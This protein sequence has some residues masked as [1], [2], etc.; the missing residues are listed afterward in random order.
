[1]TPRQM[2]VDPS[3]YALKS[4]YA[5]TAK[6]ITVHNTANDASA[7]NEIS[8]MRNNDTS[9]SFHYAIDDVEVVQGLP[10]NRNGYH[11]GDGQGSGNRE[12]TT[13]RKQKATLIHF[14]VLYSKTSSS[15]LLTQTR[16]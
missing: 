10:E 9:T 4:P 2:L 1:M 14:V 13:E 12:S 6:F 16:A 8:Y 3:K 7:N 11:A 15:V 5:M